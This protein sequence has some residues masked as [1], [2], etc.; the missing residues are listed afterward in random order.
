MKKKL[1]LIAVAVAAVIVIAALA[2]KKGE[3]KAETT[4]SDGVAVETAVVNSQ[5][6]ESYVQSTGNLTAKY[7]AEVRSE[8]SG[9]IREVYV[10]DWVKVQKGERLAKIDADEISAAAARAKAASLEAQTYLNRAERELARMQN[11]KQSG[12]ATQQQLDDA[13]TDRAAAKAR[14][15]SAEEDYRQTA[16]RLG[17]SDIIA[18]ITGTIAARNANIG[19]MAGGENS[20]PLFVI[21]DETI[22]DLNVSIPTVEIAGVGVG[23]RV[24]FTVDAYPDKIFEGKVAYVNPQ[25]DSADRSVKV[26]IEVR[27]EEKLLKSGFFVKA[28]IYTGN[29]S[30][31]FLLPQSAILGNNDAEKRAKVYVDE[32][33][34]AKLKDV[35]VGNTYNGQVEI[36]DGLKDGDSI[37]VRGGFTIKD[38]DKVSVEK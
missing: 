1:I 13:T 17:K 27:N 20:A 31:V 18:P 11:L 4:S 37:I 15:A 5:E 16:I 35:S 21:I 23:S 25:V 3:K 8:V 2:G 24:E 32:N 10:Q 6:I 34:T 28:K 12:L 14:A 29:R 22:Y 9:K 19:E 33:G 7:S 36:K 38:G 30:R 26:N